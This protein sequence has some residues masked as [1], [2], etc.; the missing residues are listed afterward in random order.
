MNCLSPL[1]AL[2]ACAWIACSSTAAADATDVAWKMHTIDDSSRGADGV[3][4]A[5][6]SGDGLPDL[7]TGWEQGGVVRAYLNPG[8]AKAT[9]KWPAVTVGKAGSVED[10]VFVDLDGD[11]A[12]DVVSCCEGRVQSVN[13]H[14]AP[15]EKEKCLE[16]AAWK[17]EAIPAVQGAAMWMFSLPLDV[18]GQRGID[19]VVGGKGQGAKIGWLESPADPRDLAAWKWHPLCDAGWIMSL[20][21]ADLDR[22]GDQDV[23]A[24]DRKGKSRGCLWLENPGR[25]DAQAAPWPVHKIGA[26]GEEVMFLDMADLDADGRPEIIVPTFSRKLFH[27]SPAADVKSPWE[28]R[29]IPFPELKGT[30]KAARAADIDGDGKLDVVLTLGEGPPSIGGVVWLSRRG[31]GKDA[32]WDVHAISGPASEKGFKPDLIQ[33]I[34]LDGDGDLDVITTEERAGLGVIWYENPGR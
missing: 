7:V 15:R 24:S 27:L 29:E 25:D 31:D 12:V 10:A 33:T 11:G 34:D 3:R 5:D 21:A 26:A 13:V 9:E 23:I 18:D 14:W 6:V 17:T 19:L 22:D 4:A 32:K 1:V 30:G 8:P 2:V 28:S 20:V 16:A